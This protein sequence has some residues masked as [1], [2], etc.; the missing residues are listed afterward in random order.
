MIIQRVKVKLYENHF[1][2]THFLIIFHVLLGG[3]PKVLEPFE[4]ASKD[5]LNQTS[6][7]RT[8]G[9]VISNFF[10]DINVLVIY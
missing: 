7:F 3:K 8:V 1:L 5:V 2:L 10:L 4:S 6:V 9:F